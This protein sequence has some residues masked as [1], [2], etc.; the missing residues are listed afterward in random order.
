[1][2]WED[3]GK[4]KDPDDTVNRISGPIQGRIWRITTAAASGSLSLAAVPDADLTGGAGAASDWTGRWVRIR[5]LTSDVHY[6]LTT[7]GA[8]TVPASTA[9]I[10]TTQTQQARQLV[11]GAPPDSFFVHPS[12]PRLAYLGTAAGVLELELA[13]I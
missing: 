7:S 4:P 3:P 6:F 10:G 5:A 1:M 8:S 2:S 12:W 13:D 9:R 11:A